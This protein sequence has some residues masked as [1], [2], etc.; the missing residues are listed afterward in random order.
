MP[1]MIVLS[2]PSGAGK[3]TLANH[4]LEKLE[5]HLVFCVS[6]TTRAPRAG[7]IQGVHYYFMSKTLFK[8]KIQ[9]E[10]FLE[11]EEVY[12]GQF[13]GTPRQEVERISLS[14][15]NVI[16]D[17]DVQGGLHIKEKYPLETLAIFIMPPSIE[18]LKARLIKRGKETP[19]KI[20]LRIAKAAKEIEAAPQFDAIVYNHQLE[21]AQEETYNLAHHFLN[22]PKNA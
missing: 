1:K 22:T 16:F 18:A 5:L 11:W 6:A 13:Y 12:P 21:T 17:I 14:G 20:G 4:L 7:E 10:E 2:A 8:Q 19:D 9:Q 15:R 3:S